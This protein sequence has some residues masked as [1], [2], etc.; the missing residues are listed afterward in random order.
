MIYLIYIQ[1]KFTFFLYSL[2]LNS[3]LRLT[4]NLIHVNMM[5]HKGGGINA[6]KILFSRT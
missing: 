1:I 3:N 6:R 4:L 5:A 2:E